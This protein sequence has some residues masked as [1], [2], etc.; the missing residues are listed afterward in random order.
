[1]VE[2]MEE[3]LSLLFLDLP[4]ALRLR[5]AAGTCTKHW[6]R[7][8]CF[9]TACSSPSLYILTTV[10]DSFPIDLMDFGGQEMAIEQACCR[11]LISPALGPAGGGETRGTIY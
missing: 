8:T 6:R 11:R 7:A 4:Q 9:V 5:D 1:M 10:A 2:W 3:C